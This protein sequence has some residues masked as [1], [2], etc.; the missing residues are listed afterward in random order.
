MTPFRNAWNR[1]I[2]AGWS[3]VYNGLIQ[4]PP[5]RRGRELLWRMA[6]PVAGER[7]LLVGVG[8]GIDLDYLPA[9]ATVTG[10]DLSPSM[11]RLARRRAED[12][13]RAGRNLGVQFIQGD[14]QQLPCVEGEFDLVVLAL[15]LSVVPEP[16]PCLAEAVRACKPGGRILV[17]DKF[18]AESAQPRPIRRIINLLTR[19]FGTDINRRFEEIAAGLPLKVCEDRPLAPGSSFR[20]IELRHTPS[21]P[22]EQ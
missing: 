10:I 6:E 2:Y 13:N 8:T 11:L 7:V 5:Y 3:L 22:A 12:H 16:V 20:A 18:L 17:F 9:G 15:I 14:A 4:L 1:V 19:V 21:R